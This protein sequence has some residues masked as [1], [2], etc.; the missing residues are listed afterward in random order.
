MAKS[1][2][3]KTI[4]SQRQRNQEIVKAGERV[5]PKKDNHEHSQ[6]AYPGDEEQDGDQPHPRQ[7]AITLVKDSAQHGVPRQGQAGF[8]AAA[9]F[10]Q[11]D[12]GKGTNQGEGGGERISEITEAEGGGA[13]NHDDTPCC[14][15][16]AKNEAV[17][18]CRTEIAQP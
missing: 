17:D 4:G 11:T 9:S 1:K 3:Q 15:E 7:P 16:P 2:K 8:Q 10:I 5:S 13:K 14:I 12:R 6:Q 18:R